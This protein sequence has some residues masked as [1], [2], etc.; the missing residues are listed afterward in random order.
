MILNA[1]C[2]PSPSSSCDDF[3]LSAAG[4][5]GSE[6][7]QLIDFIAEEQRQILFFLEDIREK[8]ENDIG[9]QCPYRR[10]EHNL[11]NIGNAFEL[12]RLGVHN[13][14]N[15]LLSIDQQRDVI[16]SYKSQIEEGDAII[17]VIDRLRNK[18]SAYM[19]VSPK[20]SLHLK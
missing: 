10:A 6:L 1:I 19:N 14:R 18:I 8:G 5:S 17:A 20:S 3:G 12:I 9:R 4:M 2:P 13:A 11:G 15:A 7:P 16:D